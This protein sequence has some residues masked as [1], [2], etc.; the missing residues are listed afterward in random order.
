M[1][2][3]NKINTELS[4]YTGTQLNNLFKFVYRGKILKI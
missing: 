1:T 2:G 4:Q 3:N